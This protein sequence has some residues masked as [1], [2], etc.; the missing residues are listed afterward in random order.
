MR[1]YQF[2]PDYNHEKPG[3]DEALFLEYRKEV[4]NVI[5]N[6]GLLVSA[7]LA[8]LPTPSCQPESH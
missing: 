8:V 4:K 7:F 3:E 1:K 2:P 6:I 5:V